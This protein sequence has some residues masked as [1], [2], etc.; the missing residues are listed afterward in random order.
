MFLSLSPHFFRLRRL[1]SSASSARVRWVAVGLVAVATTACGKQG[2]GERCDLLNYSQD[3]D[4]GLT[5]TEIERSGA[6]GAV[7]CPANPTVDICQSGGL[8]YQEDG[9]KSE[10]PVGDSGTNQSSSTPNETSPLDAGSSMSAFD[11]SVGQSTDR[12]T[13]GVDASTTAQSSSV[14]DA[15]DAAASSSLVPDASPLIDAAP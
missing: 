13:Q 4:D 9:G 15:M 11:G 5:C 12:T 3:C 2:E 7:C 14:D 1:S 6:A 10:S 8:D